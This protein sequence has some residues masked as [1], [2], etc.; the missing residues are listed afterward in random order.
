[1]KIP[2]LEY[3][4]EMSVQPL[5]LLECLNHREKPKK[6]R[7]V[8]S[9]STSTEARWII[10]DVLKRGWSDD[11][12]DAIISALGIGGIIPNPA[13]II[14]QAARKSAVIHSGIVNIFSS[15]AGSRPFRGS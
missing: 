2:D 12:D 3:T 10:R 9:K 15:L 5:W 4:N 7:H 6:D 14:D 11:D 13:Q 1:M 8:L